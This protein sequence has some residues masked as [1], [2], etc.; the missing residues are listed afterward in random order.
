MPLQPTKC[1]F[2]LLRIWSGPLWNLAG[3]LG[4]RSIGCAGPA[5]SR[6]LNS[7]RPIAAGHGAAGV[8]ATF[9]SRFEND[10]S[11]ERFGYRGTSYVAAIELSKPIKSRSRNSLWP[12]SRSKVSPL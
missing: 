11:K 7:P 5:R 9:L 4:V 2:K 10:E 8:Q 12:E 3:D 1:S 6:H